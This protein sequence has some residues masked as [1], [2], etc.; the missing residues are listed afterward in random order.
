VPRQGGTLTSAITIFMGCTI[1]KLR[2]VSPK[3]PSCLVPFRRIPASLIPDEN[4]AETFSKQDPENSAR[5]L[6]SIF[7]PTR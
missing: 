3:A 5:K 6:R 7:R 1:I 2:T 4:S